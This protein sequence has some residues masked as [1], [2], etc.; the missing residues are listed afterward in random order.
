MATYQMSNRENELNS[1]Q[2][3]VG[4]RILLVE[5]EP[6]IAELLIFILKTA[7]AEVMAFINAEAALSMLELFHPDILL[8]NIKLPDPDGNWMLPAN[9]RTFKLITTADKAI[10][11]TSYTR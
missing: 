8:S 9:S 10:A 4:I 1:L 7:G 11:I 6:D 3:L 2:N 5:D